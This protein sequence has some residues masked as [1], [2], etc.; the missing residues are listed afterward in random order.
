MSSAMHRATVA[1]AVGVDAV[2][3]PQVLERTSL[4]AEWRK[5]RNRGALAA[6][7][8]TRGPK[9]SQVTLLP[10]CRPIRPQPLPNH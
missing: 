10:A 5:Q 2:P 9:P 3:D 8:A 6:L 1:H 4:I 7:S